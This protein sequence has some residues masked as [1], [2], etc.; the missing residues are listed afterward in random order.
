MEQRYEASP[1]EVERM[2][3]KELRADFLVEDLFV[4]GKANFVYSHYDRMVMG[5]VLPGGRAINLANYEGLK[6]K[7]FLERRE[8]GRKKLR[9]NQTVKKRQPSFLSFLLLLI[10]NYQIRYILKKKHYRLPLVLAKLLTTERFINIS[11]G[12]ESIAVR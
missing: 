1:R 10:K 3:T 9:S 8:M 2:N 12:K 6:S 11:T 4:A 7:F 5:G